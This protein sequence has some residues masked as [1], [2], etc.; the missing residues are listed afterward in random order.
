MCAEG[1][2]GAR[3]DCR[4]RDVW[5]GWVGRTTLVVEDDGAGG[6]TRR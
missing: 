4:E 5:K 1:R 6:R 3:R 2:K